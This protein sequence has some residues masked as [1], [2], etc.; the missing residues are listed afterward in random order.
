MTNEQQLNTDNQQEESGKSTV[1]DATVP[2]EA[3]LEGYRNLS[4]W[5]IQDAGDIRSLDRLFIP[6]AVGS[7]AIASAKYPEMVDAAAVGSWLLLTYWVCVTFRYRARLQDRFRV[8]RK[9]E[10]E[11]GFRGHQCLFPKPRLDDIWPHKMP[12]DM[13]LRIYFYII[14]TI[15]ALAAAICRRLSQWLSTC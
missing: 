13:H 5:N 6:L 8:M 2:P 4:D 3:P 1:D 14:F 15:L 9:I 7:L 12:S 10:C 11:I